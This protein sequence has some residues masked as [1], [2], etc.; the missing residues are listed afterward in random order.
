[1]YSL[2]TLSI[3]L[4]E[5]MFDTSR[6]EFLF[7]FFDKQGWFLEHILV[8]KVF[9]LIIIGWSLM[10]NNGVGQSWDIYACEHLVS[11]VGDIKN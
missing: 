11:A 4:D 8:L 9:R 6:N 3:T 2:D 5:F 7:L 1:M 10:Q